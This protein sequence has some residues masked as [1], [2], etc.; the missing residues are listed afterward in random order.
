MIFVNRIVFEMSEFSVDSKRLA[1]NT[2]LLYGRMIFVMLIS[3]YTTR[4]VLEVLGVSDYGVYSVVAGFV[5]LF[6]VLNNCLTTGTNRFYNFAL[7]KNDQ[8]ELTKVYNASFRIQIVLITVLVVLVESVGIL[9]INNKMVIPADRITAANILFQFSIVS[10]TCVALQ[11]PYSSAVLAHERMDFYAIVSII[12]ALCKLGIALLLPSAGG[13]KLI[14]YGSLMTVISVLNFFMYFI[15]SK[16]NFPALKLSKFKDKKLFKS[17]LS[18]S[19][20]STLDPLSYIVRDQG[21]NMTLNLFF[22]TIVN[23]AYGI[24]Q[25]VSSAVTSFA[26][27][28]SVAFRPQIIQSYSSGNYERTKKL[29]FSMSKINFF[30][31]VLIAIPLIFEINTLLKIWLKDSVPD[32]AVIFAPLVLVINCFNVLN[33]PVSIVMVSTGKIKLVKTVSLFIITMV[34]PI[35]YLLFSIGSPPYYIYIAMLGLTI[36]N[37]LSCVTIMTRKFPYICM[38]EY[39]RKIASPC[40]A[41]ALCSLIIPFLLTYYI[42]PSLWR[43]PV[44]FVLSGFSTFISAYY[45]CFDKD[46]KDIIISIIRKL[47]RKYSL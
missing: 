29:M 12:D 11:I 27:N 3:F 23:A 22:G 30:L 9:Y 35:G 1:R 44:V 5:A 10:L 18:F 26:S 16:K 4:V 24:S 45:I 38:G 43:I 25:T 31:Q 7:G 34:V 17:L 8:E 42:P 47:F 19:G 41:F 21:S 28:L 33:E 2:I 13:D 40:I 14:V 46:E 15:Y 20:W 39:L 36:I 6:S 37:Q 32:Y